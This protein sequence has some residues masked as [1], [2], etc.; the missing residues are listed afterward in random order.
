MTGQ[1]INELNTRSSVTQTKAAL[2]VVETAAGLEILCVLLLTQ[3]TFVF[4]LQIKSM[5]PVSLI[6][7]LLGKI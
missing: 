3:R 7:L 4:C 2:G 5:Q 1:E 6:V